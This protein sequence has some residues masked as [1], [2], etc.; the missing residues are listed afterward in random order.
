M[1]DRPSDEH[2]PHAGDLRP[3]ESPGAV[4]RDCEP[5]R[6]DTLYV[7]AWVAMVSAAT[8]F[9]FWPTAFAGVVLAGVV[10]SMARRDR[11]LMD[12]GLMDPQGEE[13]TGR[14]QGLTCA[15]FLFALLGYLLCSAR[16]WFG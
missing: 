1:V 10:W 2:P 12:I 6:A 4:R 14:A 8:V 11:R 7:L 13:L 5:H 3:W 9:C 15:T 16:L